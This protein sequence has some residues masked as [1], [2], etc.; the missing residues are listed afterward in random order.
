MADFG[1][2]RLGPFASPDFVAPEQ[3]LDPRAAD[4]RADLYALGCVFYFLLTGRPPF[5]GGTPADKIRRHQWEAPV[6][7]D[8]VRLDVPPEIA[9]IVYAL[10]AK[11]PLSRI[12]TAGEVAE[13]LDGLSCG[14]DAVSFD[15][16]PVQPGPYSFTGSGGHAAVAETSPWAELTDDG[17]TLP[18]DMEITPV[19]TRVRPASRRTAD[20]PWAA[21][22][23]VAAAAAVLLAVVVRALGK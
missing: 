5:P 10:L 9:G 6:P 23:T 7:I 18:P 4:H 3:A 11:H 14:D 20:T 22:G 2:G 16:P 8:R 17:A 13:R 15:M 19:A 12:P 21:L 1:I